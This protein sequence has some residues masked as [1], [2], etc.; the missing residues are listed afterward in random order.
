MTPNLTRRHL[1][2]GF[3]AG[4]ASLPLSA[5]LMRTA[6]AAASA[7][8]R[9]IC[10]YMPDGCYPT[11]FHPSGSLT[12]FT[13]PGMTAPLEAWKQDCVFIRGLDMYSGGSTHE[14]GV[15]KVLTATGDLSIDVLVG[16][17][18]KQA[19]PHASVHLGVGSSH[20]NGGNY[21]SYL[22]KDQPITPED[23]PL[24]AFERLFGAPGE[25]ED[26][27][28]RRRLSILDAVKRDISGLQTRLGTTEKQKLDTHLES[29][30]AVENRIL[31]AAEE[32]QGMCSDPAW[33][34]GG[35]AVPAGYNSYP[36]YYN[37]D[38]Q[39]ATVGQL[40]MDT[41]VLALACDL[42]RSV[43]LQWSHAVSG[44]SH[45]RETG[46]GTRHHDAS[47]FDENSASSVEQF[48]KLQAWY[49][50]RL[51]Y[52]LNALRQQPAE[53]GRTL[54]DNTLVL[55]HSELGHS[56]RHDHSD[57]PFILAGHGGGLAGGRFLDL[58]KTNNNGNETH[59]KLLVSIANAMGIPINSFGYT[60]HG[61]GPLPRLFV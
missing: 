36:Q 24:R 58:R 15:R 57:M 4:A 32:S 1:L 25:V 52:L 26:I 45:E 47:H 61:E 51:A 39:F 8:Q 60:G 27:V 48:T 43:T 55:L 33:N 50:G 6:R 22:G 44:T 49:T 18:Y 42:T 31:A 17:S 19:T 12:N 5:L 14:G 30:R 59:A 40:Q 28:A 46:V 37:R 13:L 56:S 23:N 41:A 3:V 35:W 34:Q 21:V 9:L 29:V 11:A 20:E 7:P 38:D 53:D 2:R 16:Q 10:F 54:L